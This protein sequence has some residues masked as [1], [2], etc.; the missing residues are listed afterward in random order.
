MSRFLLD[1]L[2]FELF[3]LSLISGVCQLVMGSLIVWLLFEVLV[4]WSYDNC[5]GCMWCWCVVGWIV[6][7]LFGMIH[8][9]GGCR[10]F[11]G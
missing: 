8:R 2:C 9:W 4:G 11:V 5:L 1:W 10:L 6:G 3:D 7:L